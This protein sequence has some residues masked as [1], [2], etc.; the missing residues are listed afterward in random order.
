VPAYPD[1]YVAAAERYVH[2]AA[3][4]PAPTAYEA[5]AHYASYGSGVEQYGP[6]KPYQYNPGSIAAAAAASYGAGQY[7]VTYGV[8]G[9]L[10]A[11]AGGGYAAYGGAAGQQPGSSSSYLGYGGAGYRPSL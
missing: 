10:P 3:A 8:P 1:R 11:A 9:A 6:P 2:Y 5:A 4:P 7:K